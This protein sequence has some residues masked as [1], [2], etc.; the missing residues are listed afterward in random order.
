MI[1]SLTSRDRFAVIAF[2]NLVETVHQPGANAQK[3]DLIARPI[4]IASARSRRSRGSRRAAAP[5][6]RRRWPG[7][8]T[9][10]TAGPRIAPA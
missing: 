9:V 5:R 2:D 6:W 1:D 3:V 4:A 7:R 8:S 10:A